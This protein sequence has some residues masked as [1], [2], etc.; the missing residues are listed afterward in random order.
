MI[1]RHFPTSR[2][3]TSNRHALW[4]DVVQKHGVGQDGQHCQGH[5]NTVTPTEPPV[6]GSVLW[7][8]LLHLLEVG[9]AYDVTEAG[10]HLDVEGSDH[11]ADD[12]GSDDQRVDSAHDEVDQHA[13]SLQ[14]RG[15]I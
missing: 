1:E 8:V 15:L 4:R 5:A 10:G 9:V 14:A 7:V 6:A 2:E 12:D 13:Q 3:V 11:V